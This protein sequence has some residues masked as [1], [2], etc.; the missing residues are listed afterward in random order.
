[1]NITFLL[2]SLKVHL[3]KKKRRDKNMKG[4]IIL[5]VSFLAFLAAK[6]SNPGIPLGRQLYNALGLPHTNYQVG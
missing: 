2:V 4:A 3:V 1:M 5:I 6:L